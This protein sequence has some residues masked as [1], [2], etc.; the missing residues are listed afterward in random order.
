MRVE[1]EFL[2]TLTTDSKDFEWRKS[3]GKF[4]KE[5]FYDLISNFESLGTR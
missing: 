5:N 4:K 2:L 3:A 1:I